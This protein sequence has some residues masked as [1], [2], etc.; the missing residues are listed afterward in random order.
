MLYIGSKAIGFDVAAD[1][2]L[3]VDTTPSLY[4]T[5]APA[6]PSVVHPVYDT[7]A[8]ASSS[9]VHPAPHLQMVNNPLKSS[10]Y[11]GILMY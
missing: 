5:S 11:S 4:D 9:V 7:S 2:S 3:P 8:P 6:S 10:C 1:M